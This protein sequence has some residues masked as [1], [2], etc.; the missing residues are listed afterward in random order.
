LCEEDPGAAANKQEQEQARL[1][2]LAPQAHQEAE[3][4]KKKESNQIII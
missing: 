1:T 2:A 3:A 4:T